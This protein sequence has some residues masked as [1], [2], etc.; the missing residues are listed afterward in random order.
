MVVGEKITVLGSDYSWTH[1]FVTEIEADGEKFK[2]DGK[3]WRTYE[4]KGQSR[5]ILYS[6]SDIVGSLAKS[7]FGCSNDTNY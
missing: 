1:G 3:P 4:H 5:E 2:V 6:M 7:Y